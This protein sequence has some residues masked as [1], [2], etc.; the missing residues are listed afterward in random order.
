MPGPGPGP[1]PPPPGS[2]TA[3]AR[4]RLGARAARRRRG[5]GGVWGHRRRRWGRSARGRTGL[6]GGRPRA[7]PAAAVRIHS[8]RRQ[9]EETSPKRTKPPS[10]NAEL[11]PRASSPSPRGSTSAGGVTWAATPQCPA[12]RPGAGSFL[13]RLKQSPLPPVKFAQDLPLRIGGLV[14]ASLRIRNCSSSTPQIGHGISPFGACPGSLAEPRPF[15][16]RP[17]DVGFATPGSAV[18]PRTTG[19]AQGN[20]RQCPG[21]SGP[22]ASVVHLHLSAEPLVMSPTSLLFHPDAESPLGGEIGDNFRR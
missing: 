21:L 16:A 20:L 5:G 1:P 10:R 8:L 7:E 4:G 19:P 15:S 18:G 9:A 6:L 11:G 13:A 2:S 14:R 22:L 12:G 17:G 3:G